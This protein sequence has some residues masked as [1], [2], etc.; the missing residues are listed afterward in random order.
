[1]QRD[2]PHLEDADLQPDTQVA[3]DSMRSAAA[4][5]ELKPT[6]D[7]L[8]RAMSMLH[9]LRGFIAAKQLELPIE[10]DREFSLLM[11][12]DVMARKEAK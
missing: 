5:E 4:R 3:S 8:T 2:S 12:E 1:M 9:Q 10:I 11:H 7:R 6:V